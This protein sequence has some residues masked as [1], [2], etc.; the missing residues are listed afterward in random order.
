[1]QSPHPLSEQV[2]QE[3]LEPQVGVGSVGNMA[4]P[5]D[6]L[7]MGRGDLS[8]ELTGRRAPLRD[9]PHCP[10]GHRCPRRPRR[11]GRGDRPPTRA[12][13]RT[14]ASM[15]G[16]GPG[17]KL[18]AIRCGRR[19]TCVDACGNESLCFRPVWTAVDTH[20]HR[21]E[22]YGSEGW[23]F[24]SPPGVPRG[25]CVIGG[26]IRRVVCVPVGWQ[27]VLGSHH[28]EPF[29][30]LIMCGRSRTKRVVMLAVAVTTRSGCWARRPCDSEPHIVKRQ[31][32][33]LS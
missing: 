11:S 15:V 8:Y 29:A 2:S 17:A 33:V 24:E 19:W 10:P 26:F 28:R 5:F 4:R 22:I 30:W 16:L 1:M 18:G 6:G 3:R 7:D 31:V 25:P 21:L 32:R 23:G 27:P 9:P 14:T 13:L 12:H 20:G